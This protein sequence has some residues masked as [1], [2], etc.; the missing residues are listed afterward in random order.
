MTS[1]ADFLRTT[2]V[3]EPYHF[4]DT[5]VRVFELKTAEEF[6]EA[7]ST[8][9]QELLN[10][11]D[12]HEQSLKRFARWK[13][14]IESEAF[15]KASAKYFAKRDKTAATAIASST[16]AKTFRRSSR[17]QE[18]QLHVVAL[19]N[20]LSVEELRIDGLFLKQDTETIGQR[21]KR[22]ALDLEASVTLPDFNGVRE[23]RIFS[24]GASSILDLVDRSPESQ[25][26]KVF[27]NE[28]D[29]DELMSMFSYL[30]MK[31][32]NQP[33]APT[34]LLT[35]WGICIA[36]V[37]NDGL[38]EARSYLYR[39]MGSCLP[40]FVDNLKPLL[41]MIDALL[42]Y[43]KI[44]TKK[45]DITEQ[46]LVNVLWSPLLS[47]LFLQLQNETGIRIKG[48]D[49]TRAESNAKKREFYDDENAIA[50][51]IDSRVI[52]DD[53]I[54][55]EV[56]IAA[57]EIAPNC[58]EGKIFSDGSKVL[59]EAK[60]IVNGLANIFPDDGNFLKRII[61]YGVQ[62]GNLSGTIFSLH[63][64]APK[65]YVAWPEY[66][67]RLPDSSGSL[68]QFKEVIMALSWFQ[69]TI[70][71]SATHTRAA[72]SVQR[73]IGDLY[74]HNCAQKPLGQKQWT[75][76]TWYKPSHPSKAKPI[77][78]LMKASLSIQVA[79]EHRPVEDNRKHPHND[80]TY[81]SNGWAV[82]ETE[83]GRPV[84]FN[85]HT[86]QYLE[87]RGGKKPKFT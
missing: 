26:F 60:E 47:S 12:S 2:T 82:V 30:S 5:F 87:E 70:R 58:Q 77:Q 33:P 75:S 43:P 46:D 50:F 3:S 7:V 81:D 79:T 27:P 54:K 15:Q 86:L 24:L 59:R 66:T 65:L 8:T 74:G 51:K 64:V 68:G 49:S 11:D 83:D 9:L 55:G 22:S 1:K 67:F 44:F 78:E 16:T 84:F 57:V 19:R 10:A 36:I 14:V 48:G 20:S 31:E 29:R 40:S 35:H 21:I 42:C 23:S 85:K 45:Y 4:M 72:L 73:T 34:E 69:H 61:G 56:D 52:I 41:I 25:L 38:A 39:E 80:A 32:S 37:S 13:Q 53:D 76:P 63:L 17:I 62:I 18:S 28:S 71:V 6:L